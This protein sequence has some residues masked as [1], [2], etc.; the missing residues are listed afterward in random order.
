[1]KTIYS[2]LILILVGLNASAQ[3]KENPEEIAHF[4]YLELKEE[5]DLIVDFTM[6]NPE[7]A[8]K[9]QNFYSTIIGTTIVEDKIER[10][11]VMVPCLGNEFMQGDLITIKPIKT[12]KKNIVYTVRNYKKDGQDFSDVLGSEFRAVWGEVVKVL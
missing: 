2:F 8:T 1:M 11:T 10:I 6:V 9:Q 7:C 12:P 5:F 4:T 3:E